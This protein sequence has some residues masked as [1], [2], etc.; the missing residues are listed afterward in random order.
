MGWLLLASCCFYMHWNPRLI[1]LILFSAGVDFF[2][3]QAVERASSLLLRRLIL[4]GSIVINLSLLTYFKYVNFFLDS[5]CATLACCG[6]Q[7]GHLAWQVALPLGISFYTFETISYMVDVYCGRLRAVRN[8]L[9]YALFILFFPHLIAG[10]IVRPRD[11]LPQIGRHKRWDW[12]RLYLGGRW[13]LL[14]YC[15]KAILADRLAEIIDPVFKAPEAFAS[16]AIWLAV[17][18]YAVQIYFDFSGYSDMAVGLAHSL[19]FKLPQNFR[20][21]YLAVNPA[22]FWR[23]WHISLS[24]WLRDYLYLPLGGNRLGTAKTYRNLIVVML[25]G[26]LWHGASWTFVA[27][28]LYHGLLLAVHRAVTWPRL[29]AAP[30]LRPMRVVITFLL[31]SIGW[32]FFRAAN[33][34]DAHTILARLAVPASGEAL[35]TGAVVLVMLALALTFGGGVTA[36]II[37]IEKIERRM[38]AAV[39]GAAFAALLLAALILFPQDSKPFIYFQF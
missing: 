15:K 13:F 28:G 1:L 8:P 2:A 39:M 10:P 7:C 9:D 19:G 25:L 29:F 12:E 14:G 38:P 32:V 27:W 36:S 11:F 22:D 6:V 16:T 5:A 3:A 4:T 17:L 23:R 24:S 21:P 35:Q 18:G 30:A 31:V 34:T 26:G 20:W 37:R 33:F